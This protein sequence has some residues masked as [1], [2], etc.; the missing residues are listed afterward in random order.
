MTTGALP[1]DTPPAISGFDRFMADDLVR[2]VIGLGAIYCAYG[3]WTLETD[4]AWIAPWGIAA[5]ASEKAKATLRRLAPYHMPETESR[6]SLLVRFLGHPLLAWPAVLGGTGFIGLGLYGVY[7]NG[8]PI[9]G[10]MLTI[11]GVC[12]SPAV[13]FARCNAR[14]R[15]W[16]RSQSPQ[17]QG[18]TRRDPKS[19]TSPPIVRVLA[20]PRQSSAP[21]VSDAMLRLPPSLLHLVREGLARVK[22]DTDS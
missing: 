6:P 4:A 15:K 1:P 18:W 19:D 9:D 17:M 10:L 5:L 21:G 12:I 3:W 2:A 13:M 11:I 20:P 8:T 14:R 16:L 7:L 22:A